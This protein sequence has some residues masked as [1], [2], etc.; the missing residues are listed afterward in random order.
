MR[1][2]LAIELPD[3]VRQH[4]QQVL[5]ILQ[6]QKWDLE[7]AVNWTRPENWHIT[8]KF[9]GDIEERRIGEIAD[10]LAQIRSD[11][12]DLFTSG[13]EYFPTRGPVRVLSLR[14]DGDTGRL[15]HLYD[16]IEAACETLGFAREQRRFIGHITIGRA[17]DGF[18]S[19]VRQ[20]DIRE[21]FP[22]PLFRVSSFGLV[23]SQ[24]TPTGSIYTRVSSFPLEQ[25]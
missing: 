3:E 21:L 25:T 20:F 6:R 12:F 1:L 4:I 14:V 8:L 2:F 22:G 19:S 5:P 9:L 17:K 23:Q 18:R 13:L 7:S 10:A 16:Q 11:P 24:L 15:N